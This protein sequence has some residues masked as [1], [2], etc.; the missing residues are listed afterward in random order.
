MGIYDRD[1]FRT[2]SR[3]GFGAFAMWS[4]T[5]WLIV[6]NIAVFVIDSLLR[7][8]ARQDF[9]WSPGDVDPLIVWKAMMGP[10]QRWGYFSQDTAIH[11]LQLWRFITFQFLHASPSHLLW[12]MLGLFFFGPILE[13]HFGPR[14]YLAFYLSCGVAGAMFYLG[15]GALRLLDADPTTP[16]VGASAGI[17]GVLIGA[18][19]F[20]PNMQVWLWFFP[21]RLRVLAI[22]Y[23][24]WAV[25]VIISGDPGTNAGGEAAHLGGGLWGL[26]LVMNQHWLNFV[27]PRPRMRL[28]GTGRRRRVQRHQ[29]DWSKDFNR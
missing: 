4:V 19:R 1:Y 9:V 25:L 8:A 20:A 15:L 28:A 11:H 12:N 29:K 6:I 27:E 10:L 14:R 2:S 18:A 3:G 26:V 23:L 7:R 21:I 22:I 16:L 13:G 24:G 5:T 17:V